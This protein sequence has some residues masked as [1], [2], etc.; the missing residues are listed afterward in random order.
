[1][2]IIGLLYDLHFFKKLK[3][4]RANGSAPLPSIF[5][6]QINSINNEIN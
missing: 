4:N 3:R 2:E 5:I 1:M 6:Q